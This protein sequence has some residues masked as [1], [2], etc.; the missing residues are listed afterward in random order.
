MS[1]T[2]LRLPQ[3]KI[4]TGLSRSSIYAAIQQ[5]TFPPQIQLGVRSVGW[6][7]TDITSWIEQCVKMTLHD[8]NQQSNEPVKTGR[9]PKPVKL[10]PRITA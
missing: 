4:R 7:E 3:V 6:L 10:E 2:I 9:H 8:P 1:H 5:G